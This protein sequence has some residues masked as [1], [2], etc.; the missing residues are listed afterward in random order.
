MLFSDLYLVTDKLQ[1]IPQSEVDQLPER[2]G[3][4][5]APGYAEFMTTLGIGTYW[6]LL[7]VYE[8]QR[9]LHE[10][11]QARKGWDEYYFWEEGKDTLSKE[12]VLRSVLF[13]DSID[14]DNIIFN[15][16][17][18]DTLFVLPRHDDVIYWVPESFK[19]P[20]LW[21]SQ[22]VVVHEPPDFARFESWRARAGIQL[23][24]AAKTF[25]LPEL[26]QRFVNRWLNSEIHTIDL[27]HEAEK[28]DGDELMFLFIKEIGGRVQ[29]DKVADDGRVS[30]HID[31]DTDS[32]DQVA[33]FVETLRSLGFYETF[34]Y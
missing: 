4:S 15:P 13:A 16:E 7:R 12:Q 20:L 3:F 34:R 25:E 30:I 27:R 28:E 5:L 22:A 8:P 1:T 31:Y 11:E 26:Y 18:P 14:G 10:L 23:F 29:L 19:N 21:H 6:D 33:P 17:F 24:T 2:L 9:I 32:A